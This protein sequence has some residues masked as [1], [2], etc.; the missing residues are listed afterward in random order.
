[1]EKHKLALT[2]QNRVISL[3]F[4]THRVSKKYTLGNFQ[5]NFLFPKMA[6]L[7]N[8]QSFA[9][10][11]KQEFASIFLTVQDRVISSKF[12]TQ[13]MQKGMKLK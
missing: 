5:K 2:V 9:K 7:L 11:E 4:S 13:P 3:K 12:S 8:F 1:M 10:I 6:A